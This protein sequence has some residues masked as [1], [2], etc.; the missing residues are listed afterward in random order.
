MRPDWA[1][2][3]TL[4]NFLKRCCYLCLNG[5]CCWCCN[6]C[7]SCS[8]V[9]E[10]FE[11]D[12]NFPDT[13]ILKKVPRRHEHTGPYYRGLIW[14]INV[15]F[16]CIKLFRPKITNLVE[17]IFIFSHKMTL[18]KY[19]FTVVLKHKVCDQRLP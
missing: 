14:L 13:S 12:H 1:I 15:Q 6:G 16:W 2:Y 7:C 19:N 17:I 3:W 10:S 18:F 11:S 5:C 8:F 4:G 9:Q